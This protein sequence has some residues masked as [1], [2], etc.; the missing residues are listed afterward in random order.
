MKRL[1][2]YL[3][4]TSYLSL[5][6]GFIPGMS[7]ASSQNDKEGKDPVEMVLIPGGIFLMGADSGFPDEQPRHGVYFDPFFIDVHEVTNRQYQ[8]F[9]NKTN[10]VKPDFWFPEID[11]PDE[12]VVGVSWHD[13]TD[14]AAWAGKRLPTEAEWEYAAWGGFNDGKY[15]W[16]DE[17]DLSYA[18]LNSFGIAP[19]KSFKP[20]GYGI[21]D[22]IGN[23]W[24]WCSDWYD[25]DYYSS[26]PKKNPPGPLQ[27]N[28]KVLRGWA[29]QSNKY[30]A[31]VTKRHQ[32][33][34]TG[35]SYSYGFRCVR[36][37]EKNEIQE[38]PLSAE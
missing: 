14:Y 34:P 17:P 27:G 21:Y 11:R 7:F 1:T 4:F 8:I 6:L 22:M 5:I 16:G 30:L 13:A 24:E 32:S 23:V 12:P 18:N 36:S 25:K 37:A 10:H 15:P 31:K 33:I 9:M 3:L 28:Q 35:R 38:S 29:W 2:F 20:N 26:S 19:V